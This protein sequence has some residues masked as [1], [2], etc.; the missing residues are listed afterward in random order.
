MIL[1]VVHQVLLSVLTEEIEL[2]LSGARCP[3]EVVERLCG[4]NLCPAGSLV[5]DALDHFMVIS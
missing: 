2:N 3:F 4:F 1:K 5:H